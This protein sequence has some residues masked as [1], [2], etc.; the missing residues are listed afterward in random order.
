[1]QLRQHGGRKEGRRR[2]SEALQMDRDSRSLLPHQPHEGLPLR[3]FRIET[4]Q[5]FCTL[6]HD[7]AKVKKIAGRCAGPYLFTTFITLFPC[8]PLIR[9]K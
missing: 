4:R 7:G 6:A 8:G 2:A 1:M 3:M 9:T 5:I